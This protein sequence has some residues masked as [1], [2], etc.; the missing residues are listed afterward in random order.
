MRMGGINA[1]LAKRPLQ[2]PTDDREVLP[3]IVGRQDDRVLVR[4]GTHDSVL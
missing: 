4:R 2:Q 3:L 1:L